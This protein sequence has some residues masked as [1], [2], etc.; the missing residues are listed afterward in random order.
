MVN[1]KLRNSLIIKTVGVEF[2]DQH[3]E[4]LRYV[5]QVTNKIL[6]DSGYEEGE[7]I[8]TKRPIL[9]RAD[10]IGWFNKD[11]LISQ[12]SIYPC[13]VNIHGKTYK[14]GGLTG[15]GTY[16]EY[17]NFGLMNDL[18]KVGLENMKSKGQT[19]S[20]LYPYSVPY[21]KRKGWEIMSDHLTYVIKDS[22]L[23]K[24][25]DLPGY[26][27]RLPVNHKDI[28]ITYNQFAKTNHGALIR[29]SFEW[30]EY[31]RWENEE[32]RHAAVYYDQQ[33]QPKGYVLYW[34]SGDVFNIKE[35]IYLNMESQKGLWNFISAHYSMLNTVKGNIY[36][37]DP[38]AFLM[39]D[40]QITQT[41][42]PYFMAKIVD[43]KAFLLKYPFQYSSTQPFHFKITD[44]LAEWNNGIFGI[45]WVNKDKFQV[46]YDPIGDSVEVDIRTLTAMLMSYRS[47]SY[48]YKIERLKTTLDT[49]RIL[50]D[51]IP[52]EQP[53]FSD[54]F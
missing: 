30:E 1:H 21:Y 4:L 18:I 39:E 16:P 13:K 46:L 49:L 2:L 24:P 33:S 54:Y 53:Y 7:I 28:I 8:R 32:E 40:S 43:V 6:E 29:G 25:V 45:R 9:E 26:V 52:E 41:I 12:I 5:F 31:W 48:F 34:I 20:Y 15:V 22:Q 35:M 17:A 11:Q 3:N 42:R 51:I 47:P 19:I 27:E 38:L 36:K 14:M 10:V 44:P 23:P 37:N 50:E